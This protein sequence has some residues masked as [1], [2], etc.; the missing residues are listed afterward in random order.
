MENTAIYK[1]AELVIN[2]AIYKVPCKSTLSNSQYQKAHSTQ[3]FYLCSYLHQ[4]W[5][6]T[7]S[8]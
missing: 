5:W 6:Q 1:F 4:S 8:P 2:L 3:K 7:S